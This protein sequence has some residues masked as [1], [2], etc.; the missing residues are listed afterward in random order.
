MAK[1]SALLRR[2]ARFWLVAGRTLLAAS[3]GA[4]GV[5][6]WLRVSALPMPEPI[7]VACLAV[8]VLGVLVWPFLLLPVGS[9][10]LTRGGDPLTVPVVLG[11]RRLRRP[12]RARVLT[13]PAPGW[14]WDV[15]VLRGAGRGWALVVHSEG[16]E[17]VAYL[18]RVE[19][20][21][22]AA[23]AS[24][25]G[26]RAENGYALTQGLLVLLV[27]ALVAVLLCAALALWLP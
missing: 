17:L 19:N 8:V 12:V 2:V 27:W 11:R 3:A 21:L 14:S 9:V 23:P 22:D 16:S 1:A 13:I 5:L 7:I 26:V 15:Y 10:W 25:R 18:P 20:D 4:L 24:L 6:I